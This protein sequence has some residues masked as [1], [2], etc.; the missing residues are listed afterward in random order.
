M[1]KVL[2]SEKT[3]QVPLLLFVNK[4]PISYDWNKTKCKS[5]LSL[6]LICSLSFQYSQQRTLHLA[7]LHCARWN[8]IWKKHKNNKRNVMR[9]PTSLRLENCIKKLLSHAQNRPHLPLSTII[10]SW[11]LLFINNHPFLQ[12]FFL[13]VVFVL[14][15]L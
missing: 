14:V 10:R 3:I 12:S 6:F 11:V 15:V 13:C 2:S 7:T 1:R 4:I 5:N 8:Y 9:I